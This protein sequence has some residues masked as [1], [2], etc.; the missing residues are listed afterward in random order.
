MNHSAVPPVVDVALPG[1]GMACFYLYG[2]LAVMDEL[3]RAGACTVRRYYAVSG[4]AVLCALW[5]CTARDERLETVGLFADAMYSTRGEW[6]I[7]G[8]AAYLETHLPS[9][10]HD[11][12]SGRLWVTHFHMRE[13]RVVGAYATRADLIRSLVETCSLPVL[14]APSTALLAHWDG[15]FTDTRGALGTLVKAPRPPPYEI[16][17]LNFPFMWWTAWFRMHQ[18]RDGIERAIRD[19]FACD[20]ID[21]IQQALAHV[22]SRDDVRA[23]AA[24]AQATLVAKGRF[25]RV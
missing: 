1:G 15:I 24:A 16:V 21:A 8:V 18:P 20:R 3:E 12:C 5:L 10:A 9:D 14:C 6:M 7:D 13:R 4:G 23:A 19:G 17:A 25:R 22:V 11:L 2:H